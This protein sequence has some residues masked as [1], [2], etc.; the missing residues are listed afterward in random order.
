VTLAGPVADAVRAGTTAWPIPPV[1]IDSAQDKFDAFAASAAGLT[2]SG[3][4]TLELALADVPMVVTY[5]VNPLTAALVRRVVKVKYASLLNLLMDR[6]VVPELIQADCN[7]D[8]LAA[9]LRPLLADPAVAAAQRE[10]FKA[11]LAMLKAP[12]GLPSEA[13]AAAVLELLGRRSS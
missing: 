11:P 13:A 9:E 1:L 4:S 5:R 10:S 7:P 2:K 6:L 12:A 8:R 3:T